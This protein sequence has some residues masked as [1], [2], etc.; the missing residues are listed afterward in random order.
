MMI[1]G[2]KHLQNRRKTFKKKKHILVANKYIPSGK[3]LARYPSHPK[4]TLF[5]LIIAGNIGWFFCEEILVF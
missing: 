3:S 4:H 2:R 1:E 5:F